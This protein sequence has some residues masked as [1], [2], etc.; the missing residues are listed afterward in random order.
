MNTYTSDKLITKEELLQLADVHETHCVSIYLPTHRSGE[1]SLLRKDAL[2]LKNLLKEASTNLEERG[3]SENEISELLQPAKALID[4]PMFWRHQS[5]GLA[6]FLTEHQFKYYTIPIS[7]E[8]YSYI[9]SELYLKPILALFNEDR[10]FYLLTL[11]QKGIELYEGTKHSFTEIM[12]DDLVPDEFKDRVGYEY[13]QKGIQFRTQQGNDGKGS[14]HGHE[15]IDS[16]EKDE[17]KKYFRAINDGLMNVLNQD[18][19]RPLVICGLEFYHPIYEAVN[20]YS[21]LYPKAVTGNPSD[22]D[23]FFIHEEVCEIL[24]PYFNAVRKKKE[25]KFKEAPSAELVSTQLEQI[26]PAAFEGKIDTLFIQNKTDIFGLYNPKTTAV[27]IDTKHSTSNV[28][29]LNLLALE[30][31]KK[32]GKVFLIDKEYMPVNTAVVNALYRY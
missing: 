17:L 19:N 27:R 18:E 4:D 21:N 16:T 3:L 7:F 23:I 32:D 15:D 1:E 31:L 30:A 2:Q 29:L 20:T 5:D 26:I 13:E 14:F 24:E 11:K 25:H 10:P 6:L 12:V 8:A 28:S 22:K 9:S